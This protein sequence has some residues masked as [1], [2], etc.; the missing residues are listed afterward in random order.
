VIGT[1]IKSMPAHSELTGV[2]E[3]YLIQKGWGGVP[4]LPTPG[5]GN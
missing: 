2:E 5:A 4:A 3:A 1:A